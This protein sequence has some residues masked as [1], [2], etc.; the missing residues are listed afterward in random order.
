MRSLSDRKRGEILRAAAAVFARKGYHQALMEEVARAAGVGKGTVYRYFRDKEDLFFSILDHGVARLIAALESASRSGG[1][2]ADSLK[3]VFQALAEFTREN[4]PL[5]RL[6]HQFEPRERMK[7]FQKIRRHNKRIL[8]LTEKIIRDGMK[9]GAFRRGDARL[10]ALATSS[11]ASSAY[12]ENPR[13]WKKTTGALLDL[14]LH[15][16]AAGPETKSGS[17]T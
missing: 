8:G 3:K 10:W 7:Q 16:M 1:G 12:M 13:G 11:A 14:M 9:Q 2:P 6:L 5:F 4:R 17:G 15:G